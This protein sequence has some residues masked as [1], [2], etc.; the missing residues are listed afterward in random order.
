MYI[1]LIG[2][3]KIG[4]NLAKSLIM[5]K[6]NT[7]AMIERDPEKC[8]KIA[9]NLDILVIQGNGCESKFLQ[10]AGIEQADVLASVTGDDEDNLVACQLAKKIYQVKRTVARV[11]NPNNENTFSLLGIDVPVNSTS[12]IAKIIEEETTLDDLVNLFTFKRGKLAIVRVDIPN[13]SPVVNKKLLNVKLPSDSIIV[14][15]LRGDEVIVP[16]GDTLLQERDD[17]I[18]LTTIENEKKMLNLLVGMI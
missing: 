1:I 11:N 13:T 14:S 10:E 17:V 15:I 18:A 7:V 6:K 4:Y 8:R 3:G 12:I 5:N 9:E 2:G 16:K